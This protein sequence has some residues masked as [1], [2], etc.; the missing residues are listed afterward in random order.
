[1]ARINESFYNTT[2]IVDEQTKIQAMRTKAPASQTKS[3]VNTNTL[4]G[5]TAASNATPP[6]APVVDTRIALRKLQSGEALT[7]DE[8]RSL[9]LP[10]TA[11]TIVDTKPKWVKS[12]TVN[13]ANGPVDVDSNGLAADGSK[14]VAV[15]AKTPDAV[16][17]GFIAGPFPKE[18]EQFFGSSAG[19]IGYRI[20]TNEDGSQQLE[21]SN[22][23]GSSK[24]F[25]F[26]F[27]KDSTGK[28]IAFKASGSGIIG[29]GSGKG[30]KTD[31]EIA[32]DELAAEKKAKR[33][34]AYDLLYEEF[35]RYGLG[36]L[37]AGI[38]DLI[39]SD[40]SPSEFTLKLRQTPAYKER[41]AANA[42]RLANGFKAIDEATYLGLEDSYQSIMQNY[43][44][45]A[46]YYEKGNLGVQKGFEDLIG[47]NVDP[48]TLEERIIEGQKVTKGNKSII[49]TAKQFFPTLTDGDFLGYVL[50][51]KNG[52]QDIKRKVTAVEIGAGAVEADLNIGLER[53]LELGTAG[54]N[55]AQAKQGFAAIGTGLQ[56]GS[57]LAS[58]YG[59]DP[60]TQTTAEEEVFGLAGKTKATRE[61][62][63]ITGLEKATFGAKTGIS[64]GALARDRAGG[65]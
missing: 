1:M 55:K 5:I 19:V 29:D 15:V 40:T 14:P 57:Q 62:Q 33:K 17:E 20:I 18:L 51:P 28:Y 47:G 52:L 50:N 48:V 63:K 6:T 22:A 12:S 59:E 49:D 65:Y 8:K 13:T 42:K 24:T 54:I 61:R 38:K 41:F 4:E 36:S 37:V 46:S 11:P 27:G 35:D 2:P 34:S 9:G 23:P 32:A 44:L 58:I 7:D 43:G 60:Y 64:S 16:G 56:R 45:P 26:K 10:V 21:V 39:E 30:L 53:A 3:A 31:A 25:G